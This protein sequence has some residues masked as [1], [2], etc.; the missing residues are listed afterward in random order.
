MSFEPME[1]KLDSKLASKSSTSHWLYPAIHWPASQTTHPSKMVSRRQIIYRNELCHEFMAEFHYLREALQ[2]RLP[3]K[4]DFIDKLFKLT[5]VFGILNKVAEFTGIGVGPANVASNLSDA[6]GSVAE[7]GSDFRKEINF[8]QPIDTVIES[9]DLAILKLKIIVDTAA[10][11]ASR[12]YSF[13]IHAICLHET[14]VRQLASVGA[15]RMLD[16]LVTQV[17]DI[18]REQPWEITAS[19]LLAGLYHGKSGQFIEGFTNQTIETQAGSDTDAETIY[20]GAAFVIEAHNQTYFYVTEQT[21]FTDADL[22]IQNE[23]VQKVATGFVQLPASNELPPYAKDACLLEQQTQAWKDL[24]PKTKYVSAKDILDYIAEIESHL[25]QEVRPKVSNFNVWIKGWAVF[26]G[27]LSGTVGKNLKLHLGDFSGVDFSGCT[28]KYCTLGNFSGAYLS[29]AK[30]QHVQVVEGDFSEANLDGIE[31]EDSNFH[32]VILRQAKLRYARFV[33]TALCHIKDYAAQYGSKHLTYEEIPERCPQDQTARISSETTPNIK[34]TITPP[35]QN[36]LSTAQQYRQQVL[37]QQAFYQLAET[38][39]YGLQT[40]QDKCIGAIDDLVILVTK[41]ITPSEREVLIGAIIQFIIDIERYI[42]EVSGLHFNQD[43]QTLRILTEALQCIKETY[44]GEYSELIDLCIRLNLGSVE[45]PGKLN[46]DHNSVIKYLDDI[47]NSPEHFSISLILV[48][49]EHVYRWKD[50][51]KLDLSKSRTLIENKLNEVEAALEELN[52]DY[53]YLIIIRTKIQTYDFD[54]FKTAS[55]LLLRLIRANSPKDKPHLQV[56]LHESNQLLGQWLQLSVNNIQQRYEVEQ[57]G[58]QALK[59]I[60]QNLPEYRIG[61]ELQ[62]AHN[63]KNR[64]DYYQGFI[65]YAQ[66]VASYRDVLLHANERGHSRFSDQ[67]TFHNPANQL[68]EVIIFFILDQQIGRLE[69]YA[70]ELVSKKYKDGDRQRVAILIEVFE[71]I[72]S[73]LLKLK[74]LDLYFGIQVTNIYKA[75]GPAFIAYFDYIASKIKVGD[76]SLIKE[77]Y[78]ITKKINSH[79]SFVSKSVLKKISLVRI[80]REITS[81]F[82]RV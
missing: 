78:S 1:F 38:V 67:I 14:Q 68:E 77:V 81:W 45:E 20:K 24:R 64:Q 55:K 39:K 43:K 49:W 8:Q 66:V 74:T 63:Y 41:T 28:L 34:P 29:H 79:Q 53:W 57:Y 25:E 50:N 16:H 22:K 27:E 75:V 73:Y 82:Q 56:M 7:L 69:L 10:R 23:H 17:Q 18:T 70:K 54:E 59:E 71:T 33:R 21:S 36:F 35:D 3:Y 31:V 58:A 19:I 37:N 4:D 2:G 13:A 80:V 26:S 47:L 9:V 32:G 44:S 42:A 11:E 46:K 52:S 62:M 30:L 12:R 60:S 40:K 61:F 72:I 76:T 48:L 6:L 65:H 15:R 5:K 51:K